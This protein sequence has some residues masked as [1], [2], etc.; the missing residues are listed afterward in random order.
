M[1]NESETRNCFLFHRVLR[2]FN[3]PGAHLIVLWIQTTDS[4]VLHRKVSPFGNLRIK[5]LLTTS[6]KLIASCYVLHR[7]FVSRH[8]PYALEYFFINHKNFNCF[9][10]ILFIYLEFVKNKS[11]L[12][13]LVIRFITLI[14]N[15]QSSFL[16]TGKI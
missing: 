5:R 3:S 4:Y 7:L 15:C 1:L 2:C 12:K 8:P 16:T 14:L 6:P 13:L 9:I 11:Y 10:K